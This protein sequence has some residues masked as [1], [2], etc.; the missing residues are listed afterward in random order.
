MRAWLMLLVGCGRVGFDATCVGHDEDGDGIADA[1]DVCPH[2]PDPGQ[3]DSDGDGV[4]DACDPEPLV[5][6][7]RLELFATLQGSD[8]PLAVTGTWTQAA[9]SIHFDGS[10]KLRYDIELQNA[11]VA[12]GFDIQEMIGTNVQHQIAVYARSTDVAYDLVEL[13]DVPGSSTADVS[14]YDGASYLI[15]SSA[16]L[17]N[18]IHSGRLTLEATQIVD[19]SITLDGGWSGEPYHVSSPITDYHGG[20]YVHVDINNLVLDVDYIAIIGW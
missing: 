19:T 10:A 18:A 20:T 14:R 8:Q 17:P 2:V 9:D 16:P 7:Q 6:R 11:V 1:C 13:N 3:L 12:F 15:E 4:G 5:P